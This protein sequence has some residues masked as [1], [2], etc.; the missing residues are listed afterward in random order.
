MTE[1][2]ITIKELTEEEQWKDAFLVMKQLLTDLDKKKYLQLIK[3]MYKEGYKMFALF[4]KG[5]IAAVTGVI[6]LTNL[7]YGKH[8]WVHDLITDESKRSK[9]YGERLLLHIQTWGK[10]NGCGIVALSSGFERVDA[11]RFYENKMAY[12]KSSYVFRRQV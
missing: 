12:I 11:H 1:D 9:G 7:Y 2:L 10:E 6:Q 3:E 5:K 4:E 8:I